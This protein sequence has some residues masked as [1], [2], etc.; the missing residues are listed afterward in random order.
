M[1]SFN[2]D[3]SLCDLHA[4]H[5]PN[6][7]AS[8]R[9]K[10]L[11]LDFQKGGTTYGSPV[12]RRDASREPSTGTDAVLF[13]EEDLAHPFPYSPSFDSDSDSEANQLYP[14]AVNLPFHHPAT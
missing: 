4:I 9:P 12:V 1:I 10:Q 14:P 8:T 6:V 13:N 11:I 7:F 5:Q 3:F 2:A